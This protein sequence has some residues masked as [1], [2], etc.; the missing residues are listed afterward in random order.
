MEWSGQRRRDFSGLILCGIELCCCSEEVPSHVK[1]FQLFHIRYQKAA[2]KG[3]IGKNIYHDVAVCVCPP[4]GGAEENLPRLHNAHTQE[5]ICRMFTTSKSRMVKGPVCRFRL[6]PVIT[7][8][9]AKN[10]KTPE[11]S[12]KITRQGYRV[13]STIKDT[14]NLVRSSLPASEH[15]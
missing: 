13:S 9:A 8:D 15:S 2:A 11:N 14:A 12:G 10:A 7:V 1:S 4:K 6:V 3:N 5:S